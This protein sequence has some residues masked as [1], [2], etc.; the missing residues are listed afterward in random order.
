MTFRQ[1]ILFVLMFKSFDIMARYVSA[2]PIEGDDVLSTAA[3]ALFAF[4]LFWG[5]VWKVTE[6]L[7]SFMHR[8]SPAARFARSIESRDDE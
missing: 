4:I 3:I 8:P 1:A 7:G 2:I 5:F 6:L